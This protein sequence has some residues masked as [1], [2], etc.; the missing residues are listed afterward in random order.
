MKN[1][2]DGQFQEPFQDLGNSVLE[3]RKM[4]WRNSE[5]CFLDSTK[6]VP[7]SFG[8]YIEIAHNG[9]FAMV[10]LSLSLNSMNLSKLK[11][12]N[13]ETQVTHVRTESV[14]RLSGVLIPDSRLKVF[15]QH[16]CF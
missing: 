1:Y 14:Y 2:R 11:G 3:G 15:F 13:E 16:A 4:R 8:L 12:E 6:A 10:P 5:L 7:L 9:L